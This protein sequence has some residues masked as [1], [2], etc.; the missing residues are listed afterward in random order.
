M[1][2]MDA[3]EKAVQ[4]IKELQSMLFELRKLKIHLDECKNNNWC[5]SIVLFY[6]SKSGYNEYVYAPT[7]FGENTW[8]GFDEA[9]LQHIIFRIR[10]CEDEIADIERRT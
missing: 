10:Q 2:T 1:A 7:V 8:K 4:R 5:S 3:M 6:A 9:M